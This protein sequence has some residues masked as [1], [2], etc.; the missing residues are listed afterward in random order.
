MAKKENHR[1][2]A[3]HLLSSCQRLTGRLA[4]VC[5]QIKSAPATRDASCDPLRVIAEAATAERQALAM[6]LAFVQQVEDEAWMAYWDCE[7]P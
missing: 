4:H 6:E 1:S 3:V 7:S 5:E 2:I